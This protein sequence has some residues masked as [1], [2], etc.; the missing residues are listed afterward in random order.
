MILILKEKLTIRNFKSGRAGKSILYLVFHYTANDGDTDEGNA[1]YFYSA[2][3]GASAHYFVDEDSVTQVVKDG[4]TAWHC[5][6]DQKYTN[7]GAS[8]KGVIT[9][10]NS[11]GIEMCSDIV[12]GE[13]VITPATQ[14]NAIELGKYLMEKY[15]IPISNVY[16]HY[17]VTGKI[18]PAP[19][20]N[21]PEQWEKFKELLGDDEVVD[22]VTV[23]LDGKEVSV[24]RIF[25]N[26]TNYIKLRD[27][28]DKLGLCKVGYDES[29]D[30]P[31]V[32]SVTTNKLDVLL[33]GE[34]V[35]VESINKKNTNYIKLRDLD[36]KLGLCKVDYD[37]TQKIPT[38]DT[39]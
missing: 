3:R 9:N 30:M 24:E 32:D 27:Y 34:K 36:K 8:M 14:A 37:K 7:G 31:V 17:D 28:Q 35:S 1:S 11:I 2:Y 20:V 33:D 5:G 19:F 29:N 6:D 25:K 18:C 38:I 12:D 22:N 26:N 10:Q 39:I 4:D 16:R 21:H 13:Y 15:N 23:L